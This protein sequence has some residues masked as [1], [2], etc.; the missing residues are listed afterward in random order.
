MTKVAFETDETEDAIEFNTVEYYK[1]SSK[2]NVQIVE[3]TF[4]KT[5]LV[6]FKEFTCF[7]DNKKSPFWNLKIDNVIYRRVVGGSIRILNQREDKK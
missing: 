2:E 7:K 6:A 1:L 4:R 3:D 5:H